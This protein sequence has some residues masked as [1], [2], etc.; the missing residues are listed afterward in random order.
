MAWPENPNNKVQGSHHPQDTSQQEPALYFNILLVTL[1]DTYNLLKQTVA[2]I[3]Q[4]TR[5]LS[6]IYTHLHVGLPFLVS[7]EVSPPR[8]QAFANAFNTLRFLFKEYHFYHFPT[9]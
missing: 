2:M 7:R 1:K 4:L 6:S 8:T 3:D 9:I 5:H